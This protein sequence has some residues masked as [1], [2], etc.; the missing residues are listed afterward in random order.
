M[1]DAEFAQISSNWHLIKHAKAE[2]EAKAQAKRQPK[3]N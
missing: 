2:A 3:A 1:N